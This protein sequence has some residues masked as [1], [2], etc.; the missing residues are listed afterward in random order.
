MNRSYHIITI[1]LVAFIVTIHSSITLTVVP[2]LPTDGNVGVQVNIDENDFNTLKWNGETK[3]IPSL[4]LTAIIDFATFK[5]SRDSIPLTTTIPIKCFAADNKFNVVVSD[6][7]IP[8][9]G[10]NSTLSTITVTPT[11]P[12]TDLSSMFFY[13]RNEQWPAYAI[14]LT[15][16]NDITSNVSNTLVE[17]TPFLPSPHVKNNLWSGIDSSLQ[18]FNVIL[19]QFPARFDSDH[20]VVFK[21]K[22]GGCNELVVNESG[23]AP[24]FP[25][26]YLWDQEN[27]QL[28]LKV[29]TADRQLLTLSMPSVTSFPFAFTDKSL[30]LPSDIQVTI[31]DRKD[32]IIGRSPL[33]INQR[34]ANKSTFSFTGAVPLSDK[35]S[36]RN[37]LPV[38]YRDIIKQIEMKI[39]LQETS[40]S[41][42]L[43]EQLVNPFDVSFI[44]GGPFLVISAPKG[45][46]TSQ[47]IFTAVQGTEDSQIPSIVNSFAF[48]MTLKDTTQLPLGEYVISVL[49]SP[50]SPR[51]F[52][53][54]L[55]VCIA[56]S[57]LPQRGYSSPLGGSSQCDTTSPAKVIVIN[58]SKY[59]N[60]TCQL[61]LPL[62]FAG[63]S[64]QLSPNFDTP[65]NKFTTFK[66]IKFGQD[67]LRTIPN[68]DTPFTAPSN[69]QLYGGVELITSIMWKAE[70]DNPFSTQMKF[71]QILPSFIPIHTPSIPITIIQPFPFVG[72]SQEQCH[73]TLNGSSWDS[74][75]KMCMCNLGETFCVE[76]QCNHCDLTHTTSCNGADVNK[77]GVNGNG[78]CICD[79]TNSCPQGQI[80]N[81]KCEC[82]ATSSRDEL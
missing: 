21:S 25:H 15:L 62:F 34:I 65:F 20:R 63:T 39:N 42:R 69:N 73:Q 48:D 26:E 46:D 52:T 58:E 2:Q 72:I 59:I 50:L 45:V 43:L 51:P 74:T 75:T 28:V 66:S 54:D 61:Y 57:C 79:T 5:Y 38:T 13:C 23:L 17:V 53:L 36:R 4:D 24:P 44:I 22:L 49:I 3:D 55:A 32:Y 18:E 33:V 8:A 31:V 71:N 1:V 11:V 27:C 76:S 78:K 29:I 16:K 81:A 67:E 60:S 6:V 77:D 37:T 80:F 56:G 14:D 64:S 70:P 35:D 68:L 10:S 41:L 19:F 12:T 82:V 30:G 47:L 9:L 40:T 7:R